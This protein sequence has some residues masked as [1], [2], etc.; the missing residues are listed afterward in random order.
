MLI[1]TFAEYR[2][3]PIQVS[4][5]QFK[6]NAEH[7]DR[8]QYDPE[9]NWELNEDNE[10]NS[11]NR[12]T[13]VKSLNL[14]KMI[15]LEMMKKHILAYDYMAALAVASEIKNEIPEE[16]Y[17]L[18]KVAS[19]RIK[20]NRREISKLMLNQTYDLYPVKEGNKQKIFEYALVLQIKIKKQEYADFI[21]GVTPLVVDLME[22]IL[23]NE[24]KISLED[25]CTIYGKEKNKKWD[26]EK[27]DKLGLL[28]F[29]DNEYILAGG[30]KAGP[31]YSG[32]I[33]KIIS[34]KSNDLVLKQKIN[35]IAAVEGNVRNVAA[36]EIVSVTDEWFVEK[37]GKN[38]RE[39]FE[40]IKYLIGKAGINVK[41]EDWQSY[42]KMNE[43]MISLCM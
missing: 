11:M 23:K 22:N 5:P 15:K 18:L 7:E 43:V 33:A 37:T 14:L 29:L 27:L 31:V 32:Q 13:E 2:F 8:V 40:I 20:L 42:D 39:I 25:C 41:K 9:V 1:P 35:E 24:C 10:E 16:A 6:M 19:E 4:T 36:H 28:D 12:C 30:F 3:K 17:I 34:Y 26:R 21:R 38:A